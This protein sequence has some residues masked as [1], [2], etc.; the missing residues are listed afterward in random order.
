MRVATTPTHVAS[1]NALM[2]CYYDL[3]RSDSTSHGSKKDRCLSNQPSTSS[4]FNIRFVIFAFGFYIILENKTKKI[5]YSA[6]FFHNQKFHSCII[7]TVFLFS[8][9]SFL[10]CRF[11]YLSDK[12]NQWKLKSHFSPTLTSSF[13]L[14]AYIDI[15]LLT[16]ISI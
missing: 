5:L 6:N 7:L 3:F 13:F 14:P 11:E 10:F 2:F 15:F 8:I 1:S 16:F 12:K 4:K 9:S